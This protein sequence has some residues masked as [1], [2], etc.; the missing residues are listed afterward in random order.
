MH[1]SATTYDE[2][3]SSFVA[4]AAPIRAA[5][6]HLEI[7][8]PQSWGWCAY[9]NSAV[10]DGDCKTGADRRAHGDVPLTQWLVAQLVAHHA[11]TGVLLLTHLDVHAYPQ[12][13]G[14]TGGGEDEATGGLRLRATGMWANVS[15]VD[16]SWIGEPVAL[17]PRL[18]GWVSAAGGDGLGLQLAA[19]EF[20]FGGDACVTAGVAHVETLA[21]FAREGVSEAAVWTAPTPGSPSAQAWAMFLAFSGSGGGGGGGG[22]GGV[23]NSSG[24]GDSVTGA[25]VNAT[26]SDPSSVGA[27]A[28]L[29]APAERLFVV[30][31]GKTPPSQGAV[32][33]DLALAWPP[34]TP[35]GA[36]VAHAWG[37]SKVSPT[38]AQLPDVRVACGDGAAPT[39]ITLQPWS[40]TLL[41]L[42]PLACSPTTAQPRAA[43]TAQQ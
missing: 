39:P 18:R 12:A 32:A 33:A 19:S 1:P 25:P 42:D 31:T 2:L 16:E 43:G 28:F 22:G 24:G 23:S 27:F 8:G 14:V 41:V 15:Y 26:S 7:H 17:L 29:D 5:Y 38:L 13:Q 30:L 21:T 37:F 36:A 34:G 3:W 35:A 4:F 10:Q 11:A 9:F 6:P 40:A 20:N